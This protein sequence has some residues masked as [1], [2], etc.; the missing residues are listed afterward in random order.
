MVFGFGCA[1]LL[2][3]EFD[4]DFGGFFGGLLEI[5][6]RD[7]SQLVY[8]LEEVLAGLMVCRKRIVTYW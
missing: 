3:D 4:G 6:E 5:C 8:T 7:V 1:G 2:E